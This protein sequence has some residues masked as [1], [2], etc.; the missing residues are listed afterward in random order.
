MMVSG[1]RERE[2]GEERGREG[3]AGWTDFFE[4]ADAIRMEALI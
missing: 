2:S 4:L 3:S 1:E